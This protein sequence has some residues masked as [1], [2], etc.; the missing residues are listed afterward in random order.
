[1]SLHAVRLALRPALA[2][3]DGD[4]A[5]IGCSGGADSLALAAGAAGLT[6]TGARFGAIIVDHQL[7]AESAITAAAAAAACRA[8]GLD[9]V[10]V[11]AVTVPGSRGR[12]GPEAVARAA[13]RTAL[14]AAADRYGATAVLLAHTMDDQAETV[15]L[16]LARGSGARSLG[17]MASRDGL[18]RR[19]LLGLRRSQLAAACAEAGL[20]PHVDP[21]NSDPSYARVRVRTSLLPALERELGPGIAAALARSAQMLRRDAE[22]LDGLV[23][24][25][26]REHGFAA[27]SAESRS[28]ELSVDDVAQLPAAVRTRVLRRATLVAGSPAA[29]VTYAHIERIDRLVTGWHGQGAVA[30]PGGIEVGRRGRRLVWTADTALTDL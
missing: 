22:V 28:G 13:R 1:M 11:V 29:A 25:W 20:E 26:W 17:A 7:Q 16:R 10:E 24:D 12:G 15:L 5:L 21:H 2:D 30:V 27:V 19:P 3:L 8:L 23:A 18:W 4:L 6:G 14:L 9:P